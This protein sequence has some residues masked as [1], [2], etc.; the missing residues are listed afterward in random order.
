MVGGGTFASGPP[1]SGCHMPIPLHKL[2]GYA[3]GTVK[4]GK[5]TAL[6]GDQ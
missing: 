1:I 2:M 3:T 4:A 6:N 5:L